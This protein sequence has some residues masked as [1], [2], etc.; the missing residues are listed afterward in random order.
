MT[1]EMNTEL[2]VLVERFYGDGISGEEWA[3][4]RVHV[5]Y[6]ADCESAFLASP[7]GRQQFASAE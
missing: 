4:L 6:C 2:S 3:L 7:I 5:A 1:P